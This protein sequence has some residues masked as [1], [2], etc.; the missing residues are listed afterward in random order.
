[1]CGAFGEASM[2]LNRQPSATISEDESILRYRGMLRKLRNFV[3]LR[4]SRPGLHW[5]QRRSVTLHRCNSDCGRG[6]RTSTSNLLRLKVG[7]VLMMQKGARESCVAH[8]VNFAVWSTQGTDDDCDWC[9][10]AHGRNPRRC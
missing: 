3:P 9:G 1:M 6:H 4:G 8:Q 2:D 7:Y 5:R 10:L